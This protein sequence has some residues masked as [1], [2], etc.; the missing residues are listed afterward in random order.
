MSF[1]EHSADIHSRVN[2]WIDN[3]YGVENR[4]L[5]HFTAALG[6]LTLGMIGAYAAHKT[7]IHQNPQPTETVI[8][9]LG[10]AGIVPT[11]YLAYLLH[12][13]RRKPPDPPEDAYV[14][15]A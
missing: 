8:E 12:R 1:K 5:V 6:T 13:S 14:L 3:R 9:A 4:P 11:G 2:G 15:A 10:G 7:G